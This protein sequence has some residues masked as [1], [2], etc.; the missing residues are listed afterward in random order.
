VPPGRQ[1]VLLS[2]LLA[3][4]GQTVSADS[5][6]EALWPD[7]RPQHAANALQGRISQLR[8]LLRAD[9]GTAVLRQQSDGYCLDVP[10]STIDAYRFAA[11]CEAAHA[12]LAGG[13]AQDAA[14]TF[15][16][17]LDL[18]RGRALEDVAEHAWAQPEVARLEELRLLA[19]EGKAA[20]RL[21]L[22]EGATLV[23]LL[24]DVVAAH[25][26]R[27]QLRGHLMVALYRAGRQADALA[28][29]REGRDLLAEELGIDPGPELQEL[30]QRILRQDPDLRVARSVRTPSGTVTE[31]PA[32]EVPDPTAPVPGVDAEGV[33]AVIRVLL[34]DDHAVV[35]RGMAAFLAQVEDIT[36]VGQAPD[37]G[38]ALERIAELERDGGAPDVVL[39]DVLM[40]GMDGITATA[41]IRAAHPDVR[42]VT[43]TSFAEGDKIK[44]AL[45]AGSSGYVLKHAE[46]EEVARA[47]RAAHRGE[48]QLDGQAARALSRE[49]ASPAQTPSPVRTAAAPDLTPREEEVLDLLAEGASNAEIA[50][51]LSISE[52]TARSHLSSI[53][54]KLGVRSRTQAALWAARRRDAPAR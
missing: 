3:H 27:E 50:D 23:A 46:A 12:A 16:E 54:G 18:W 31:R 40:P 33:P 32:V 8:Q 30:E 44:A 4:V 39:M 34:V 36:V 28:V 47:V 9:G 5:L 29:Y 42:V 25:P 41:A 21:A 11:L 19:L 6:C 52:R 26:M 53:L 17:A 14:A 38:E 2:M 37:G 15:D 1:R 35:R 13:V 48:V 51:V 7:E 22:G 10:P 45:A 20:A 49:L 24:E 43:V